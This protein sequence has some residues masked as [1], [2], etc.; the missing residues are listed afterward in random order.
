MLIS[1]TKKLLPNF[2]LSDYLIILITCFFLVYSLFSS[3]VPRVIN[4]EH[5]VMLL[6]AIVTAIIY[7]IEI[8]KLN[9]KEYI[10][11]NF[12]SV[13]ILLVIIYGIILGV[14]FDNSLKNIVRDIIGISSILSIFILSYFR[15]NNEKHLKFIFK[16]F[17]FTGLIF[18]IKSLIF[19]HFFLDY[20][21]YPE[22]NPIQVSKYYFLYLENTVILS[23]VYFLLKIYDYTKKRNFF[24]FTKYL[25][26]L[27][28]PFSVVSTY[29]LRGPI[30][31]TFIFLLLFFAIKKKSLKG[32]FS[33]IFIINNFF[34][35][36]LF[37]S[38]ILFYFFFHTK[39]KVLYILFS[40]SILLFILDHIFLWSA[41]ISSLTHQNFLQNHLIKKFDIDFGNNR[42]REY[43]SILAVLN[44]KDAILGSGFGALFLNPVN[45]SYVLFFHS[46]ILY[47]FYKLGSVGLIFS[48]II[49]LSV[50]H[51]FKKFYLNF[52]NIDNNVRNIFM[53]L[54]V[55]ICYPLVFS[56][57]YK[58]ITF[59]FILA[60][61]L[62]LNVNKNY[63]KNI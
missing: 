53:S 58:S 12:W 47:Y 49:F 17:V 21:N 16:V 18:S 5:Y 48:I 37:I 54:L 19:Y 3:N 10:M 1:K 26:L 2:L 28:F 24:K 57:T 8:S 59:G 23:M 56:A 55:T 40:L 25:I 32:L 46:F 52:E 34:I 30:L 43:F 63:A 33:L 6:L 7:L 13:L 22:G 36:F 60:Y 9:F 11:T 42:F 15:D 61:F 50:L 4:F 35:Y 31:F 39:K 44:L 27:F 41:N 29:A 14:I 38:Y 62:I 20:S 45:N 51:K